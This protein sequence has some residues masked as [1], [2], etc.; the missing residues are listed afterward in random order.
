MP[1]TSLREQF[2]L[3]EFKV[4]WEMWNSGECRCT[5][6]VREL[7]AELVLGLSI[8]TSRLLVDKLMLQFL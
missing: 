3:R 4:E 1:L 6:S 8:R 2:L 7:F 5:F